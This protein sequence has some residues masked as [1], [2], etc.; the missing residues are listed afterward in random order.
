MSKHTGLRAKVAG[1]SEKGEG[2]SSSVAGFSP[3]KSLVLPL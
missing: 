3:A 1:L 2:L